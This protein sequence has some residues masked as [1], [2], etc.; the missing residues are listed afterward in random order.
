MEISFCVVQ[1]AR[2]QFPELVV[3]DLVTMPGYLVPA[4]V[5]DTLV[6]SEVG[7]RFTIELI[8][9]KSQRVHW[10]QNMMN[11]IAKQCFHGRLF[12]IDDSFGR[13]D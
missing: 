8:E 4:P 13:E 5:P 3:S 6:V 1:K 9:I 2:L 12:F 10:T 11:Q 7:L